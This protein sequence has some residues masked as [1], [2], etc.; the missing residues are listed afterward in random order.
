[1]VMQLLLTPRFYDTF[2]GSRQESVI[3]PYKKNN[4]L[5]LDVENIRDWPGATRLAKLFSIYA[6]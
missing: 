2:R 6:V 1:M 5:T 4:K 3:N